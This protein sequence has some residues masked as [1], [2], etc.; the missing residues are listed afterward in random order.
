M[1]DLREAIR[2]RLAAAAAVTAIVDTRIR[3]GILAQ[4]D[5]LP[6]LTYQV[7]SNPRGHHL[8]GATGI[9][10]ARVQ[11]DCCARTI[12]EATALKV[13]LENSLDGLLNTSVAGVTILRC[14]QDG[15][16]DLSEPPRSG[17]DQWLFRISVDYRVK[18]RCSIPAPA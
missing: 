9:A 8:R 17:T 7:V 2:S 4:D 3:P 18:Y 14:F 5:A 6:A 10:D 11:F 1:A 15:E 12:A 13:A 16:Q